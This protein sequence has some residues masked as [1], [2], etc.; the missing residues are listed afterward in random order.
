MRFANPEIGLNGDK[1]HK[2][3]PGKE[4]LK[5]YYGWR[6]RT[7]AKNVHPL[8]NQFFHVFSRKRLKTE[9]PY[10]ALKVALFD[11]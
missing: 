7:M 3:A 1:Y 9:K 8:K 5:K 11:A 10:E 4:I 2:L 6:P